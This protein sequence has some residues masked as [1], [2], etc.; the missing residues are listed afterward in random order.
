MQKKAA[1]KQIELFKA[2]SSHNNCLMSKKNILHKIKPESV[3][4]AYKNYGIIIKD[5]RRCCTRHLENNGDIK[6][7]DIMKIRKKSQLYEKD[8]I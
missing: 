1:G 3:I 7:E 6:H 5:D 8:A 2:S 4:F